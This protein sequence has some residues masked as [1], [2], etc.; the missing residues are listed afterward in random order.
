[1]VKTKIKKIL[2]A[3]VTIFTVLIVQVLVKDYFDYNKINQEATPENLKDLSD[4]DWGVIL[5]KVTDEVNKTCPKMI[6]KE[7]RL[8]NTIALSDRT[9]QYNYTMVNLEKE[10]IDIDY[11]EENL[12]PI[13]LNEVKTNPG[14]KNF[15][16]NKVTMSYYYKDKNGKFLIKLKFNPDSYK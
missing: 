10:S 13:I 5:G 3:I 7:T 2:I 11:F 1:M 9:I 8:D 6:D 16:E 15:R 4:D 12:K 14:L